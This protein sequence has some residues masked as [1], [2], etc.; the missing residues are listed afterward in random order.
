MIIKGQTEYK[1][2]I[3]KALNK[4]QNVNKWQYYFILEVIGLFLSR[5]SCINFLQH[6]RF[7]LHQEQRYRGQFENSFDF[8][9][10]N[11]ELILDVYSQ[12]GEKS[13]LY[14]KH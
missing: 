7:G 13:F 8:I 10:F 4:M 11:K 14:V 3:K 12:T 1:Y 9:S 2:H 5:K 6:G